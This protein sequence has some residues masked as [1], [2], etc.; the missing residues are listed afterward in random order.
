[1][2]KVAI[3]GLAVTD[4]ELGSIDFIR[5]E[6]IGLESSIDNNNNQ[7]D[8]TVVD[9]TAFTG[10]NA[11]ETMPRWAVT[12]SQTFTSGVVYGRRIYLPPKKYTTVTVVKGGTAGSSLTTSYFGL[13]DSGLTRVAVSDDISA[14][15]EALATNTAGTFTLNYTVTSGA[16]FYLAFL[17]VGTTPSLYGAAALS[18]LNGAVT[19]YVGVVHNTGTQTALPATLTHNAAGTITNMWMRYS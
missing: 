17:A 10:S 5:G 11:A 4:K 18:A 7:I 12:G 1:M 16:Y 15:L 3:D 6:G 19:P 9:A 13:Y 2:A 14:S 8:V